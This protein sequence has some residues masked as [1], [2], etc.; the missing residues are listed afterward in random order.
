MND[1]LAIFQTSPIGMFMI[2]KN[3]IVAHV[4]EAGMIFVN[5][6]EGEIVGRSLGECLCCENIMEDES[7]CGYGLQC[8]D[9]LLR[10]EVNSTFETGEAAVNIELKKVLIQN[11]EAIDFYF[12]VSITPINFGKERTVVISMLDITKSTELLASKLK[13]QKLLMNINIGFGYF[14]VIC[15]EKGVPS[16][17]IYLEVN[18]VFENIMNLTSE[19]ILG[20]SIL[21][22]SPFSQMLIDKFI[23]A[24]KLVAFE[25]GI[26]KVDQIYIPLLNMWCSIFAYSPEKGYLAII[27]NDIT[28]EHNSHEQLKIAKEEAESANKAKSEFLANMSHEIRTPLNGI[29]GMIDLTLSN[30]LSVEQTENLDLAKKCADSLLALI[31]DI[32]DFSKIEAGKLKIELLN[33]SV[34][35]L[36]EDIIKTHLPSVLE[37]QIELNSIFSENTPEFIVGDPNRL[38]QVLNNIINNAVKFTDIGGIKVA[39]DSSYTTDGEV[40]LKFSVH[41]TGIGIPSDE[42]NKLF[43]NFSQIDGSRTRKY[44]GAGLGLAISKQLVELMGGKIWVESETG[45]GTVFHFTLKIKIGVKPTVEAKRQ[46]K[47]EKIQNPLHIL[48]VEDDKVNQLVVS[49]MLKKSGHEIEIA[50]NGVEA[51]LLH[52]ANSYDVIIMDIQMPIMDGI[53]TTRLIREKE[54]ELR[55]TPIIALTAFALQGD[56]ERFLSKGMDEYVSKPVVMS[57]LMEALIRVSNKSKEKEFKIKGVRVNENGDIVFVESSQYVF[58]KDKQYLLSEISESIKNLIDFLESGDLT[59]IQIIAKKIKNYFIEIEA[60]GL[61]NSAFRI[62]LAARRGNLEETVAYAMQIAYEFEI[63]RKSIE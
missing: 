4:N 6:Q 50:N 23:D 33:F 11:G 31:N 51:L 55:H 44:G 10:Q 58:D 28:V 53:E 18:K 26:F 27:I 1:F 15:D 21:E 61:K 37:K 62:E 48:L 29:L 49:T 24:L 39:V 46:V 38:R 16:D 32:L 41:D 56:R 2:D 7:G 22:K 30:E 59:I 13:Y 52:E 60:D 35:Q 17:C 20:R 14:K 8:Q 43:K 3:R 34:K 57:V 9:C 42:I 45:K 36:L 63:F 12:K 25:E 19:K 54:G 47:V 40:M 5:K